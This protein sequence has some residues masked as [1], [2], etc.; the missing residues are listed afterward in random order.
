MN[1]R[2]SSANHD[3]APNLVAVK[4]LASQCSLVTIMPL[5]KK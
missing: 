1:K 4:Y 5:Q 2:L 3:M